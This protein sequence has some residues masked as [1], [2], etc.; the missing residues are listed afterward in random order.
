MEYMNKRGGTIKVE[1]IEEPNANILTA[2]DA[3]MEALE[4]EK[5]V[6]QVS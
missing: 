3:L 4:M 2:K 5:E 6:N 1:A